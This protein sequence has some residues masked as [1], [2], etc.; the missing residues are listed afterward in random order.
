LR[1]IK[2]SDCEKRRSSSGL[3]DT[4]LEVS[5]WFTE[6]SENMLSLI[7]LGEEISRT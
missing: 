6:A 7:H 3:S 4:G 5:G 2:I 1:D